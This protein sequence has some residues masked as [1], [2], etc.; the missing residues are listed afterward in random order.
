MYIWIYVYIEVLY[1]VG[2]HPHYY[3]LLVLDSEWM[4]L[5]LLSRLVPLCFVAMVGKTKEKRG[6]QRVLWHIIGFISVEVKA[7]V[8]S[9]FSS[10]N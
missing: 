8:S 4:W 2:L 7:L 5:A 3:G 9:C 10:G 1:T 6:K